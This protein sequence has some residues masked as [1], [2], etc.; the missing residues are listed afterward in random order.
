MPRSELKALHDRFVEL[1]MQQPYKYSSDFFHAVLI[2]T[3][4][5]MLRCSRGRE[6]LA[7]TAAACSKAHPNLGL[8]SIILISLNRLSQGRS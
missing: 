5:K 8:L 4:G 3:C 1:Y 7:G 2:P 6:K